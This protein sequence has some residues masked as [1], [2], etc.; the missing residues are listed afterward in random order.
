MMG[1]AAPP[2]FAR[3]IRARFLVFVLAGVVI[4]L[5]LVG[6][7]L[8][9]SAVRSGESMLAAQL[10][11]SIDRAAATAS[12]RWRDR[13][14][15]VALLALND[16]VQ[17]ALARSSATASP[18]TAPAFL[19]EAFAGMSSIDNVV[20][21]D[22]ADRVRWRL[23]T[24]SPSDVE[25]IPANGERDVSAATLGGSSVPRL[26]VSAAVRDDKDGRS[27]GRVDASVRASTML[28]DV[29]AGRAPEQSI[30]AVRDRAS[31]RW[32][33]TTGPSIQALNA[34]RFE[35]GGQ[36]WL[37]VRRSLARP[38]VDLISAAPL[39]PVLGPFEA[40][41]RRG[42]A[43]LAIVGAVVVLIAAVATSRMTASLEQ[44]AV[45]ADAV[46]HGDLEQ[47]V[48]VVGSDEVS[49]VGSA[50]NG[51]TESLRRLI[52]ERSQR[53]ALAAV[54]ELAATIA[55]QVR[56]PVTAMKLDLQRA[57]EDLSLTS[58]SSLA[59]ELVT[60]ALAEVERLERAV[61]ASLR[62]A[63]SGTG[64]FEHLDAR[65]PLRSAMD[66]AAKHAAA[67]GVS[68][69]GELGEGTPLPVDGDEAAL[70]QMF[71]NVVNNAVEAA[72]TTV[73]VRTVATTSDVRVQIQDDGPAVD[74]ALVARMGEPFYSTKPGGTGLGLA[75]ARRVAAAH[76]GS[77]V[78]RSSPDAGTTVDVVVARSAG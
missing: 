54:G 43:A 45:A 25:G 61:S 13:E 29:G 18:D 58:Q 22:A 38:D 44:L 62:I 40:A 67:R 23:G 3:S 21:R 16:P 42:D 14:S 2:L 77:I 47:R 6:V 49:R 37:A 69:T 33:S 9:R 65:V 73:V 52:S 36:R 12:Q 30:V 27:L 46:A 39:D 78:V 7:W 4:P 63:R 41:A 64:Q 71:G 8:A 10:E 51:M 5:S 53:E 76:R 24:G 75:I 35:W 55:H 74:A 28:S 72:R 31:G 59:R 32:T 1:F 50:F 60:Q 15:D 70:A 11:S 26:T 17:Q 66:A 48:E 68:L 34:D 19:R 20:V 57:A 56:S